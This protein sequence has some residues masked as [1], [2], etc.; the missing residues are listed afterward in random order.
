MNLVLAVAIYSFCVRN[1]PMDEHEFCYE[2]MRSCIERTM[3]EE[4]TSDAYEYC[5]NNYFD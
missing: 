1:L 5:E 3:T 2:E 4:K